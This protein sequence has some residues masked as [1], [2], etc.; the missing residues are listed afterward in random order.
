MEVGDGSIG[1]A[2]DVDV[3]VQI[4]HDLLIPSFGDPL[5]SI[6][7]NAYP[8]LL[9]NMHDPSFFQNRAILTH[10]NTIVDA[11]NDYMFDLIPEEEK[12]YLSYDSP[13]N[14]KADLNMS[15]DVYAP[16]FLI[17]VKIKGWST[18]NAIEKY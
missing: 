8:N 12:P 3:T 2:N 6:V 15:D 1:D 5:S 14:A 9:Q 13:C 16:E 17:K 18:G 7:E 4:P 11:I 10:K